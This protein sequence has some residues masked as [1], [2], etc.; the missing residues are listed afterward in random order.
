MTRTN[1]NSEIRW[2]CEECGL[3]TNELS[4]HY[5]LLKCKECNES[6][7]R[8]QRFKREEKEWEMGRVKINE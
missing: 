3:P 8:R 7:F 2:V 6:M 1:K 5:D 4:Q